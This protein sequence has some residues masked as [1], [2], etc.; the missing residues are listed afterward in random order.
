MRELGDDTFV[1]CEAIRFV[2]AALE[3]EYSPLC[4]KLCQPCADLAFAGLG[5]TETPSSS[6]SSSAAFHLDAPCLRHSRK[7]G[8]IGVGDSWQPPL[9]LPRVRVKKKKNCHHHLVFPAKKKNKT[10]QNNSRYSTSPVHI[11]SLCSEK[12][13]FVQTNSCVCRHRGGALRLKVG[14]VYQKAHRDN[15]DRLGARLC[16]P[17][18]VP[19]Q[20]VEEGR[21]ANALLSCA[22]T[23]WVPFG[24]FSH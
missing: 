9:L 16:D 7:G 20:Q 2:T 15:S 18:Q 22:R 24:V 21:G 14:P 10:D 3:N 19:A 23:S 13:K 4:C 1:L 17:S 8:R 11:R 5:D 12:R 6:R